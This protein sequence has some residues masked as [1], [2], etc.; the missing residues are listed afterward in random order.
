[1]GAG[2]TSMLIRCGVVK[3]SALLKHAPTQGLLKSNVQAMVLEIDLYVDIIGKTNLKMGLQY[4]SKHSWI[5]LYNELYARIWSSGTN[6]SCTI[7][8]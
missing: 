7:A 5:S 8:T 4:C 1:M 3:V 6:S 2:A